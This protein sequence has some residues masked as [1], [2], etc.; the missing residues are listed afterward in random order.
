VLF[1]TLSWEDGMT[2][3][4]G[5]LD[6]AIRAVVAIII[7]VLWLQGAISGTLALI[8]GVVAVVFLLTS[9]MG[10]CPLYGALGISTRRTHR[11]VTT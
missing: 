9:L 8:L 7:G 6:R 3:N 5:G 10:S 1:N 2:Q 4:M 11:D